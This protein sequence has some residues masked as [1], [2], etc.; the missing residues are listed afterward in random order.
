M[1]SGSCSCKLIITLDCAYNAEIEARIRFYFEQLDLVAIFNSVQV[2]FC[3]IPDEENIY[4]RHGLP[5]PAH[6]PKL[7]LK[8]GP[9]TQFFKSI[10]EFCGGEN[11][12]LLN[13]VDCFPVGPDWLLRI[14]GL[15]GGSEPFWVLGSPYRGYGKLG[16][17]IVAHV[18]GNALYG[19]G[20]NGFRDDLITYWYDGLLCAISTTPDIAYDIFLTHSYH[21]ILDP[22]TWATVPQEKFRIYSKFLCKIRH[23]DLIHNLAGTEETSGRVTIDLPAYLAAHPNVALVHG[24]FLADQVLRALVE[25][26]QINDNLSNRNWIVDAGKLFWTTGEETLAKSLT[27]LIV[28]GR[29]RASRA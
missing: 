8:S 3:N 18:N 5:P 12:V 10:L 2:L 13:E 26:L 22:S 19:V 15:V 25:Q 14:A 20:M 9:N 28:K 27:Q 17:D 24:N 21:E 4:V 23:T 11:T 6:I 7:G 1:N 29:T 16:P